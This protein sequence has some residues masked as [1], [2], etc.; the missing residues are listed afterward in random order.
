MRTSNY[1]LSEKIE[2]VLFVLKSRIRFPGSRM[3]RFPIVVRGKRY[4][5]FGTNLTTGRNCRIEVNGN[6]SGKRILFGDKVN[7]GD[8]VSIRCADKIT[9]GN[10]V[11]MGSRVL[12]IDNSHGSYSGEFHDN[13]N[14]PPNERT[15]STAQVMIEDN[16]WLGEGVVVQ[17]GVT[18]GQ[19]SIIAANS[20]VTK[21]I[22]PY[23][24]AGGVPTKILKVFDANSEKWIKYECCE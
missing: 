19:G 7:I 17:Q 5:D 10:N 3:I 18:I 12:I 15:L 14:I 11:L 8:Y 4:I 21:D 16:V 2:N 9:I 1:T 23:C 13:P 22:P 24:I 6:H 20:V